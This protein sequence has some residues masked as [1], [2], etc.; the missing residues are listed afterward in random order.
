MAHPAWDS[1]LGADC[2]PEQT[3]QHCSPP[4]SVIQDCLGAQ[5]SADPWEEI[6]MQQN[7]YSH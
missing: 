1:H 4:L 2:C 3:L 5:G 7:E 6:Q